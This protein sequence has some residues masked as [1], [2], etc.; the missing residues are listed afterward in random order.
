[1]LWTTMK[2]VRPALTQSWPNG[3]WSLGENVFD[4][5]YLEIG[6]SKNQV[7]LLKGTVLQRKKFRSLVVPL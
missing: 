1:M 6:G 4:S 3:N 7:P 5:E 2:T